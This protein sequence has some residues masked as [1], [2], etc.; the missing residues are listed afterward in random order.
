MD[1]YDIRPDEKGWTVCDRAGVRSICDARPIVSG[2]RVEDAD[3]LAYELSHD[4]E[5]ISPTGK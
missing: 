2:L 4:P 5:A 3:E 1:R